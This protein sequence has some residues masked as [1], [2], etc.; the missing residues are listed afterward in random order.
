MAKK[1]TKDEIFEKG[2]LS[3][4]IN[5]AEKAIVVF[6]KL[7]V[8]LGKVSKS[9][10]S[11]IDNSSK[12]SKG[13]ITELVNASKAL[14]QITEETVRIEKEKIKT[15]RELEKARIEELRLQKA[16]EKS[17]DDYNK[18][19]EKQQQ[20]EIKQA[21]IIAEA[22]RPYAKLSATLNQLRKDY[23][24]LAVSG[25]ENTEQAKKLR[26]EIVELDS[27]LKQVDATTGQHQR[28]VGNY[29]EAVKPLRVQL[30]ELTMELQNMSEADPRF[31]EM[32]AQAGQLRDKITDTKNVIQATAGSGVENLSK[33]LAGVGKVGINAFQGVEGAL[34]IFGVESENVMRSLQK[35][36]ALAALSDAL[37]GLGGLGDKITEI[38]ASFMAAASQLGIFTTAKK[39]DIAVTETQVVATEGATIATNTL[40][41][42][43]K[44]LPI[45]A[46][47]AG[48]AGLVAMIYSYVT[49]NEKA[50]QSIKKRKEQERLANEESKKAREYIGQ[51]SS[52]FVGLI[53]QLKNT[54][55]N[56]KERSDL[57]SKINSTYGTTLKNIQD[58]TLFQNQLNLAVKEY[59][60]SV[61]ARY[62]IDKNQEL[63]NKNLQK[64]EELKIQLQRKRNEL[65]QNQVS[66]E[67]AVR[68]F[69][70]DA[71]NS[72]AK[73]ILDATTKSIQGLE[74]ELSNAEKRLLAY[75]YSTLSLT[76]KAEQ[77]NVVTQ[78]ETTSLKA[79]KEAIEKLNVLLA[80]SITYHKEEIKLLEIK[81]TT[82]DASEIERADQM[83]L[84]RKK[85][86]AEIRVLEA[87][88][89][90]DEKK[91]ADAR[92]QQIKDNLAV[93][94]ENIELSENEKIRLKLQAELD[95]KN[96]EKKSLDD[97]K[98]MQKEAYDFAKKTINAE[99]DELAKASERRQSILDKDIQTQKDFQAQLQAQANAGNI[100]AQQSI[101][102]SIENEKK[103]T[104]AK[105]KEQKKQQRIDDMK[106]LFN[107]INQ[108]IDKGDNAGIAT[109]K[110]T[111]SMA[112]IKSIAGMFKGFA[113]GT[114]WR[115][116]QED[117]PLMSGVDGHV[118]RVDSSEAIV[119]GG[120]MNKAEKAGI[121]STEQ[122]VNS[123]IM[124]QT[125]NP[126]SIKMNDDRQAFNASSIEPI[127]QRLESLE[128]T[129]KNKTE[130]RIEP[131]ILHG[132][133]KG[134]VQ[135]QKDGNLTRKTIIKS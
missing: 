59:I 121:R 23:K 12:N 31:S 57:M 67:Q 42:S 50:E 89:T 122:L 131:Y 134:I 17:I 75:G 43:M 126:N 95:I 76:E 40:G 36:Q 26:D 100:T 128:Q 32:A 105:E 78:K 71:E 107:L 15:D 85:T 118:V 52:E 65:L 84:S 113:K 108:N 16:R 123:A 110:A 117:N 93:E 55:Q 120:L 124:Y 49:S 111:A 130:F 13:S 66:Y 61:K 29:T 63:I 28:N 35:L 96:I 41:K 90:G 86:L 94:L 72:N 56:S 87:E 129:I 18:K 34:A 112:L 25:N 116:G 14:N 51:E 24:D 115:L 27:K 69:G 21:R 7:D 9:Y 64:Q 99:L 119:N 48:I 92:I 97:K 81:R 1:I 54:N 22:N 132:I 133:H 79:K 30:R 80:E 109:V 106:T 5:E 45:I 37:E 20:L 44:A 91:I 127:T 38:K 103:A 104:L 3:E 58:E 4:V 6:D 77:F 82:I 53:V 74:S 125:F 39:V 98:A 2:L 135:I 33:G 62:Q 102:Q 68:T 8:E 19:L 11:I 83:I 101:A 70:Q 88:L 46:I 47:I 114:K 73:Q 10:K 60:E